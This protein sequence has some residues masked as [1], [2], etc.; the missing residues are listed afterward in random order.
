MQK[1]S[2]T[3]EASKGI[4]GL[5][6]IQNEEKFSRYKTRL[7]ESSKIIKCEKRKCFKDIVRNADQ[8]YKNHRTRDLYK[9]I[10]SLSKD[11][12]P[13]ESF[14]RNGNNTLL[15]NKDDIVE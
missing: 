3:Q 11:F 4:L 7:K 9:N 1:W 10:N 8:D 13:K 6:D 14:L 5:K 12:K 2:T 15:M